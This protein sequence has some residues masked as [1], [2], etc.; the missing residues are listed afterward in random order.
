MPMRINAGLGMA[1][2]TQLV[3]DIALANAP[4]LLGLLG[5]AKYFRTHEILFLGKQYSP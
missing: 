1:Q 5:T 2:I 3:N 4:L